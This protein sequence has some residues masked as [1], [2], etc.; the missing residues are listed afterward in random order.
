MI[1]W[2]VSY[3]LKLETYR[4]GVLRTMLSFVDITY[5]YITLLHGDLL[6]HHE[7]NS[8]PHQ[9]TPSSIPTNT[10][11]PPTFYRSQSGDPC[12]THPLTFFASNLEIRRIQGIRG[13]QGI[14]AI[15]KI[16]RIRGTRGSERSVVVKLSSMQWPC[17]SPVKQIATD[18]V[19]LFCS[20][21]WPWTSS[22][23]LLT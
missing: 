7:N 15:R 20:M 23:L 1:T 6:H 13:I 17:T 9:S 4:H 12:T 5:K 16:R 3:S 19:L 14:Q 21:P 18:A 2:Y 11:H 22:A 10:K 8:Q